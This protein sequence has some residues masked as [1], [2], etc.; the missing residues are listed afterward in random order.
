MELQ[1]V[2][3]K[4]SCCLKNLNIKLGGNWSP[5]SRVDVLPTNNPIDDV[6]YKVIFFLSFQNQT[7]L[8]FHC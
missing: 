5:P 8:N 1:L 4:L 3:E 2:D 6:S 7:N